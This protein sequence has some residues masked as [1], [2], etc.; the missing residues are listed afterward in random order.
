MTTQ[1][2]RD[3]EYGR[4]LTPWVRGGGPA[5]A[6][7]ALVTYVVAYLHWPTLRMQ[8]DLMV[9][10]FAGERLMAG[11]DLYSVGLTGKHDEMLFI[12]PPFAAICAVALALLDSSS[13]QWLWLLGTVAALTYAVVRMLRSMG[14]RSDGSLASLAALLIGVI[15]WLAWPARA[16]SRWKREGAL[17]R[18]QR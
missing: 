3:T 5:I 16:E 4:N 10:R 1:T 9:Y 13:A 18:R 8:V 2:T 7:L 15:V 17:P 12:Y 6:A 14:M 11:L